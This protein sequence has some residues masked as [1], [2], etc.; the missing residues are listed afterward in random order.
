MRRKSAD[1][2]RKPRAASG[3]FRCFVLLVVLAVS[4]V[5]EFV[6]GPAQAQAETFTFSSFRVL[7]NRRIETS[8]ILTYAGIEA[9]AETTAAELN[10]AYQS[11]LNS[12]LFESVEFVPS[13]GQLTIRVAE[14]PTINRINVEGNKRI[15]DE[16]AA[17]I[18]QSKPRHVFNPAQI[19]RDAAALA[20]AY[21]D[22]GRFSTVVTPKIIRLSDNRVDVAFEVS[23]T[24]NVEVERISFV[25]NRVYSDRRLRRVLGSKQAGLL[26][27]L[28]R[29]DN[30]VEERIAFDRLLLSDFYQARGYVDFQVLS[31]ASEFSRE[32]DG[33]FLTFN[34]R[35]GQQFKLGKISTVSEIDEISAA[36]FQSV[37]RLRSGQV[38]SPT[39]IDRTIS[40][41]EG[42]ALREG[43]NFLRVEPRITRNDRDLTLDVEFALVRGPRIFVERIDIEGNATTL[44]RVIR[45]QFRVVEGDP[46]NPREI[47][48]AAHR[49]ETLDLF[50]D[51][52]ISAREGTS[53]DQVIV[54]VD[55]EEQLT[56]SLGFGAAYSATTGIGLTA[57]F[58][59]RNLM[60]RGQTLYLDLNFGLDNSAFGINFVE[61][62]FMGRDLAF[63]MAVD[64]RKT[65]FS[66]TDYDTQA[67]LFRPAFSFPIREFGRLA[68]RYN[69]TRDKVFN[70]HKNSSSVL[71]REEQQGLVLTSSLGYALTYDTIGVGLNPSAG[72]LL[73]F[74]Q[75]LSGFGGETRQL[76]TK[77]TAVAETAVMNEDVTLR[78]IFEGG[79]LVSSGLN[80]RITERFYLTSAEMRGFE[81]AG[82]GPRDLTVKNKDALGGNYFAVA[83]FE[84]DF[85]LGFP[86]EYRLNGGLFFDIGSVWGLD[87]TANGAVDDKMHLRAAIG[88]SVLWDSAFGPLRFNFSKALIKE[89]YDKPQVFELTVSTQF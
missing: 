30:F 63:S 69:H 78:A 29:Q 39:S 77:L 6:A 25:G 85:P 80:S 11:V 20:K 59:E 3:L 36:Q 10:D 56:G 51:S 13:G 1:E 37:S 86:E 67:F 81:P 45:R 42:V 48:E 74:D 18:I 55:V 60:G 68:V 40:R 21:Q 84:A 28:V 9:G 54:S 41:M 62:A 75:D 32:R 44:D 50:A 88:F 58:R 65:E 7:G 43:Y 87:D 27:R 14:Y 52:N 26:R 38:Y 31:V 64:F 73:R 12:G 24:K 23:E 33:F 2:A 61:P 49:I 46:F 89:K 5:P 19:E 8:T 35:E 34:I 16:A 66:Y 79:G 57:N 4:S 15:D 72:V 17:E 53:A 22:Q 83:R 47:R 70:V 76:L 82:V 71:K